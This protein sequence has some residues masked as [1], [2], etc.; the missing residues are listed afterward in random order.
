MNIDTDPSTPRSWSVRPSAAALALVVATLGLGLNL[1]AWILLSPRLW[2]RGDVG[3]REYVL[4][5]GLPLLVAA[6][7]R[8]PV[9]VLAAALVGYAALAMLLL[10]GPVLTGRA[11][12]TSG[13]V[14]GRCLQM[15]RL[16][17]GTSLTMLYALALGGVVAVAVYL[18]AYLTGGFGLPWLSAL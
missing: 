8:L 15:L 2:Q 3:L 11:A 6:A 12:G 14:L 10:P 7:V 13:T 17:S 9:G 16:A 1:R 5:M 4:L 18:P